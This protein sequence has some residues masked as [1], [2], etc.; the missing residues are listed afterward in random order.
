L[1]LDVGL[2]R[3]HIDMHDLR[4]R[5]LESNKTVS[6]KARSKQVSAAGSKLNSASNSRH[7]SRTAS[8]Q[9]SDEED[10]VLSDGTSWSTNSLDDLGSPED[11]AGPADV[12]AGELETRMEQIIDRKRSSVQGR[13]E[14]LRAYIHI[15]TMRFSE[16][17]ITPKLGDLIP[18][19]LKS[20]KA[21]SS[22]KETVYALKALATTM[23][24]VPSEV[25]YEASV[26]V[27]KRAIA[28]SESVATKIAAVH[29]L[30]ILAFYGD[31]STDETLDTM[32]F[33]LEISESDGHS[34]NA[35][36][37]GE[38]VTAAL[39]EW[40]FLATQMDDLETATEPAMEAFV[41]QLE[42]S[43]AHVQIAAGENIALLY[44]KSFT[45]LEDDEDAPEVEE[46]DLED[47]PAASRMIKRYAVYRREDQLRHTLQSLA[48]VSNRRVN[49]KDR[50]SL[51]T[52]F[53]DILN[54]V[55]NPTRGPR[56]QN[57]VDQYTGKHY[58]SRMT[59]RI[60]RTGEMRIDRW[61]KLHR[62]KALRRVLQGGFL[63]HYEKNEVVFESLP[64]MISKK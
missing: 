3:L 6:R 50:K 33:L 9:G 34:V 59:V 43:D 63:T 5:A 57:A 27:V 28:D 7:A 60:H 49:K 54:T 20:I 48:S 44:E 55:E 30:A 39:E 64:V 25:T 1:H 12:L 32:D 17:E 38:V 10:D 52:N 56:Y 31:I 15:L 2:E 24:T 41:E 53:A 40:A 47:H 51:H 18:A 37:N 21:E 22:E 8:R 23:I 46:S 45:E 35:G 26:S 42:S 19:I 62:L 13:E 58:G 36:D 61:W 4:R 14:S 29:T 16:N 11:Y